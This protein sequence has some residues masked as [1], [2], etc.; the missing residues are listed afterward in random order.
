VDIA[1]VIRAHHGSSYAEHIGL[2]RGWLGVADGTLVSIP[3]PVSGWPLRC[4][5]RRLSMVNGVGF[6][7][8]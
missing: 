8:T 3:L 1:V 5:R 6:M 4:R 2:H 7:S